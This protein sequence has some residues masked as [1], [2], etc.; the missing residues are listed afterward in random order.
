MTNENEELK[1]LLSA[2][3]EKLVNLASYETLLINEADILK[4]M[5]EKVANSIISISRM[6]DRF[7]QYHISFIKTLEGRVRDA[8]ETEIKSL[9]EDYHINVT[10]SK[11]E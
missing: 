1:N 9:L 5:Y 10:L 2:L 8:V 11:G 4:G 7:E 3:N 6:A